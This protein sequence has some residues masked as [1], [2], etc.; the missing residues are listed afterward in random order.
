MSAQQPTL[1][2]SFN[3]RFSDPEAVGERFV[4]S[5][6]LRAVAS[7]NNTAI[8]GPRGSGKTTLLKMLTLPALKK[9][10]ALERDD[11][12]REI[13]FL[14][15]YIPANL[16]WSAS[17]RSF[18]FDQMKADADDLLSTALFRHYALASLVQT[19]SDASNDAIQTDAS[20]RR[21]HLST[22]ASEVPQIRRLA[23]SWG[24][25][26]ETSTR[27]GL[28]SALE[29]SHTSASA[30]DRGMRVARDFRAGI[31]RQAPVPNAALFRR[32]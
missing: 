16:T 14:A 30:S 23:A 19:W 5:P 29:T 27:S 18:A 25:E 24:I 17:Y 12:A 7:P 22:A 28:R 21:F 31:D 6:F 26:A 2:Q 1:F 15:V 13:N 11:L 4:P 8:L 32:C 3:A 20:L 9:W 10:N